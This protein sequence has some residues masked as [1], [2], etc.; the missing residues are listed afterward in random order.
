MKRGSI[1][2]ERS[3]AKGDVYHMEKVSFQ[4]HGWINKLEKLIKLRA[5][6]VGK[7]K[8]VKMKKKNK[9]IKKSC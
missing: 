7:N 8:T 5:N 2:R 6:K 4:S 3:L 9:K 1:Q